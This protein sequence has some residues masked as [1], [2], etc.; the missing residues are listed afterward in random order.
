MLYA[1]DFVGEITSF[2]FAINLI[3]LMEAYEV[4]GLD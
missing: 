2:K 4:L 3:G 1:D